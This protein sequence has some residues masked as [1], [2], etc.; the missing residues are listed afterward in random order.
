MIHILQHSSSTPNYMPNAGLE[1]LLLFK[2]HLCY[3][4]L[5]NKMR[6]N[7]EFSPGP[8]IAVRASLVY[9]ILPA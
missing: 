1:C 5:Y 3:Y 6:R 8:Q 7:M 4:F 2:L 9:F